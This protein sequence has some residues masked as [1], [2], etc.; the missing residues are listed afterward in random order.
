[1]PRIACLLV[2]DLPVAAACRADPDLHGLPLALAD[3]TG[4]HARIVAAAATARARGVRPGLHSVAQ[5]R[6]VTAD[7]VV[8]PRNVLAERSAALALADVA[9]SLASRV[10][11]TP[12]GIV[13]ADADGA[14]HLV[15]SEAGLAT[16]LAAR[17]ARVGLSARIGVGAS[18]T[19]ARLVAL[20][21]DGCEVV[22]A[23]AELGFLAPLPLACLAPPPDVAATLARWGVHRLG[24]LA[25]LPAAEVA[26]RLGAMGVTLIRSARGEDVR[27]LA[28]TER[29]GEVEEAMALEYALDNLEPLLFVLR[30]LAER[31]VARLGLDGIGCTRL[32]LALRLE[33]GARDTRTLPL[34]APTR[35]VKTLLGCLRVELEARPPAAA[36]VQVTITAVPEV[37]RPT[38][39]GLFTPPG[40]APERLATTLARLGVLCGAERVG[41]P[42]LV[43]T[44][45]P[46]AA[47]VAP[48]AALAPELT[49]TAGSTS[50]GRLVVRALRPPR[51]LEVFSERD[52]PCFVRG[53][54][55]GGRVVG[56]AGPWRIA[57]EWWGGRP[58]ARE[59]YDLELTDGGLYRCFRELVSGG[60]FVDGV[61]D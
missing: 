40:P 11:I 10:E 5:A 8:R 57:A 6:A 30:G 1:M 22:P 25:R 24:D 58:C 51:P 23:G 17:A 41:I 33:N 2:P 38:Q 13:L 44:H 59:Y 15:G 47:A 61:Y 48:F 53:T 54:G 26:T 60:W 4:P 29:S 31:A 52:A 32:G 50:D 3:G 9:A 39:L 46:G 20:H 35:D 43:D 45:R 18:M 34:A 21:G 55:L 12:D 36:I 16:A 27:P 37:I 14:T 7:L 42:V 28:P 56:S 19:V 49:P